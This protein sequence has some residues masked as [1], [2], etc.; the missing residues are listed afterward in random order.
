MILL[1]RTCQ[2]FLIPFGIKSKLLTMKRKALLSSPASSEAVVLC[3][4][5]SSNTGLLS[6][7]ER[8]KCL[9]S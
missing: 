8:A 5:Y 3:R 9:L 7:L 6:V 1:L 2:L 4:P